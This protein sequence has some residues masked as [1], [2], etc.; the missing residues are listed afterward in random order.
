M[1]RENWGGQR[2]REA[3]KKKDRHIEEEQNHILIPLQNH[4]AT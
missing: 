3:P 2:E 4:S 1:E